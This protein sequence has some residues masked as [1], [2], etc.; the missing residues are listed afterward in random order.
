MIIELM[1]N[2]IK[3]AFANIKK[4]EISIILKKNKEATSFIYRDN[5][6]GLQESK[7]PGLGSMIIDSFV[8]KY[9]G[10]IKKYNDSGAV[11][12]FSLILDQ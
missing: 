12:E 3:Y 5:G 1:T 9:K 10:T 6:N 2:S 4:P 7:E 8:N 11:F